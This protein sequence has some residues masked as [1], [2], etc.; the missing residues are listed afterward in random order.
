M[1]NTTAVLKLP[2]P[3]GTDPLRDGDNALQALAERLEARM[4]LGWVGF[5]SDA[6]ATQTVPVGGVDTTVTGVGA[7]AANLGANRRVRVS[8]LFHGT[9]ATNAATG[10]VSV[11][12]GVGA[13]S[14]LRAQAFTTLAKPGDTIS[15][16]VMGSFVTDA[17]GAWVFA[18]RVAWFANA[19]QS[20]LTSQATAL[21][22]NYL[23]IED[24]G[25]SVLT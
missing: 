23:L 25:P 13:A 14:T 10:G 7:V 12:G 24:V 1:G 17:A 5:A 18:M 19:G 21:R 15:F 6:T 11:Y 16:A 8:G 2:Y 9:T 4:P 20:V 22:P 3:V